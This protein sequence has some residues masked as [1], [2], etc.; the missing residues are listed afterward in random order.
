MNKISYVLGVLIAFSHVSAVQATA[1][2]VDAG[3][4]NKIILAIKAN[5]FERVR[6]LVEGGE[7]VNQ[8]DPKPD[9]RCLHSAL[10]YT[11]C[12]HADSTTAII[13]HYLTTQGADVNAFG[14]PLACA[15]RH[16]D[17]QL[18]YWLLVAYANPNLRPDRSFDELPI[19]IAVENDDLGMVM[20]L[21]SFGA[22][23]TVRNA[24]GKTPLQ[25]A[26]KENK[27]N[28]M[29]ALQMA[30]TQNQVSAPSFASELTRLFL[31]TRM[32]K[33]SC[34]AAN[35]FGEICVDPK[36]Q[37]MTF[38]EIMLPK[39]YLSMQK[40]LREN[41]ELKASKLTENSRPGRG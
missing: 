33:L 6:Q 17:Q 4:E 18:A 20:L 21:V 11:A 27:L 14:F 32:G 36:M 37:A 26:I 28:I 10:I 29:F 2:L 39:T 35:L 19:F 24:E 12:C 25:I 8:F 15:V 34:L 13:A 16:K 22:D 23:L 41:Q 38:A 30:D 7:D 1:A 9:N 3:R 5:D 31:A 40:L